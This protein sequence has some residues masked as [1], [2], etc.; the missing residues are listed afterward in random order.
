MN[1]DFSK[2]IQGSERLIEI[3]G[4]WPSFHDSEVVSVRLDR[5]ERRPRLDIQVHVFE[6]TLDVDARGYYITKD[7]TLATLRFD[8]VE[9]LSIADFNHQNVVDEIELAQEEG[10]G[11]I[12]VRWPGINGLDASF[13]CQSVSVIEAVPFATE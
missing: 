4:T 7:H 5:G 2:D 13:K 12:Q 9:S 10:G 8:A 6:R 1:F 3:F 11:L